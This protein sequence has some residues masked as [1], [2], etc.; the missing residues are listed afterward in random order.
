MSIE[1]FR[2]HWRTSHADAAGQI[3]GVQRYTQNHSL[4][5][6]GRYLLGYPGFDACSEL[7]FESVAAMDAGFA[8]ETYATIVRDDEDDFV[9]KGR[10]SLVVT[11]PVV[12]LDGAAEGVKLIR[13]F[14]T[15]PG[16]AV[17]ALAKTLAGPVADALGRHGT[18]FVVYHPVTEPHTG[19]PPA[20][21]AIATLWLP[22]SDES[23]LHRLMES[24]DWQ[25][26]EWALAGIASGSV[27][28]A[29]TTVEVV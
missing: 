19:P 4:L 14:R 17:G 22:G 23:P 8:S 26:A 16:A 24:N 28:L 27:A 5:K 15:N 12:V 13:M 7:D 10:F 11:N 9:D 20:F 2:Q 1:D 29:A 6:D 3:P 25:S 21:E 18:R